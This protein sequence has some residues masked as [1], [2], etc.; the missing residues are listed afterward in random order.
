MDLYLIAKELRRNATK[1]E[2]IL[3]KHLSNRKLNDYKFRSQ[4]VIAGQY[5]A[6]FYCAQKRLIIEVDGGIHFEKRLKEND[7]YRTLVLKSHGYYVLRFGND[8]VLNETEFVLIQI[9]RSIDQI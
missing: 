6:D 3:W 8:E 9:L 4:A 1:A 7:H 5:I 2:R